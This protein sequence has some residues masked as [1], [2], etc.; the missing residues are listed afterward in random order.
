MNGRSIAEQ[1]V[2]QR[3]ARVRQARRVDDRDV[4]VALLE[5]VDERALV[6]AT[7]TCR[8]RG[9][10]ALPSRAARRGSRRAS[11]G[12][13][14]RLARAEQVEVRALEHEDAR[15]GSPPADARVSSP[16]LRRTDV[17]AASP[18]RIPAVTAVDERRPGTSALHRHAGRP[19]AGPSAAGPPACFLSV[20]IASRTRV[21]RKG[22]RPDAQAEPVEQEPLDP[23][24]RSGGVTP[25]ATP[26]PARRAQAEC[27]GLAV[28]E[29]LVAGRRLERVAHACG[30][31]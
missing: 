15:H 18:A 27:H 24:A 26:D 29:A 31:G 9:R 19:S 20:P 11:R 30:P 1:R 13:R 17:G 21:E 10:A 4:E 8:G 14:S 7:G 22:E 16:P 12:R 23:A 6:V 2:A 5:P 25:S 28:E 3:D